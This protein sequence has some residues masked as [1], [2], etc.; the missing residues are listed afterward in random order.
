MR[1]I[2]V[3]FLAQIALS[4]PLWNP[5]AGRSFP[6]LPLWGSGAL[7]DWLHWVLALLLVGLLLGLVIR[8]RNGVLAAVTLACLL[9][10]VLLD[11]N[12]LQVWV[13]FYGL[14]LLLHAPGSRAGISKK[15]TGEPMA[16]WIGL[17]AVVYWWSGFF[18]ITPYFAEDNFPW[19]CSAFAFT[20]PFGGLAWLGYGTG[21]L[22][23]LLGPGLWWRPTRRLACVLAAGMHLWIIAALS[24]WGLHWNAVVIPWNCALIC[25]LYRIFAGFPPNQSVA[26]TPFASLWPT[27]RG[28][29]ALLAVGFL[30]VLNPVGG[31]PDVLSWKMY[32]NTQAEWSL[33]A[34]PGGIC[35]KVQ[36]LWDTLA[37]DNQSKLLL[38]DWSYRELNTPF[39][40]GDLSVAALR[41][42]WCACVTRPDSAGLL[43][44]RVHQW[45]NTREKV[46][47]YPCIL[48]NNQ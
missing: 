47:Y 11:L 6:L 29:I 46:Q 28:R 31:W 1:P 44:L 5:A 4:W 39:V 20:K 33:Y 3:A 7:P 26:H 42:Y 13:Y 32:S 9:V 40:A 45:Y 22:E 15:M 14:V 24:P 48:L 38:D 27:L 36:P 17:L 34:P 16:D 30:P 2:A 21:V 12:R 43:V 37:Y 18:K 35:P 8:P 19:L 23:M 25:L 10:L 41:N